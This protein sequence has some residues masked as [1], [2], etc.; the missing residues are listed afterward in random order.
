MVDIHSHILPMVDDGAKS[1]EIAV[2]MVKMAER[3]GVTHMVA[4]P[5]ANY[6]YKYDR[7]KHTERLAELQ[8]KVGNGIQLLL[9]C[10]FHFSSDNIDDCA[11]HPGRYSIGT[12]RYMLIELS[13]YNI[14][15][16]FSHSLFTLT[17]KGLVPI[18]THP[19]RNAI[20][21]KKP[22]K[23]QEWVD[24]GLLVQITANAFTGSWGKSVQKLANWYC[25]KGLA[26]FIASDAHSTNH[27]NP[28]L[29][30][31]RKAIAKN[32]GEQLATKLTETNPLAVVTNQP[33]YTY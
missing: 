2:E 16:H 33:I 6:E 32:H 15:P 26:H 24:T 11:Q 4:T 7:E 3:D 27:R 19:E 20:L 17:A 1:W 31:A 28:I 22:E 5:H 10:D 29:S 12:S 13:D 14:S 8:Q 23:V 30:E 25:E 18:L 9:G 21:Q